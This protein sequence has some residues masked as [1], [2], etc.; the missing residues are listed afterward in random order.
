M[1]NNQSKTNQV[2]PRST[3]RF[4]MG[5]IDVQNDFCQGGALAVEDAN[6][7][8]A[9]INKLRFLYHDLMPTFLSQDFHSASHMSFASTHNKP[10]FEEVH[11]NL[12]MENGKFQNFKQTMWPA[13]CIGG[14][15]GAN[16]HPD[17]IVTVT[18][19]VIQK[20][21]KENVESYS[22]FGDEFQGAYERTD[23][24]V[25]LKRKKITDII[26]TGLAT[27]YCVYRTALDAIRLGFKVHLISS[28]A[29]GVKTETTLT[30]L[31]E[32]LIKGVYVYE[33][34]D[35]FHY[36]WKGDIIAQESSS[37]NYL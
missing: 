12:R 7:I 17:L 35:E 25:W 34:V 20:G 13:H 8:L 16:L 29:R 14:T 33:T 11:L 36:R 10:L 2:H 4:V 37:L 26:L 22:A 15:N 21:T 27:D 9:P 18:D 19:L 30:A 23:L 6:A 31:Q 32:M 28:C 24:E 1:G 5:I 3:R